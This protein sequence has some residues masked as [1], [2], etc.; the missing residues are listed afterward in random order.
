MPVLK[1]QKIPKKQLSSGYILARFCYY[2]P[3]YTFEQA[4]RL[5]YKRVGQLL[6]AVDREYARK[7]IDLLNIVASPHTKNPKEA[8]G[9]LRDIFEQMMS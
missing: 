4:R 8:I 3:Q 5:P 2:F 7:M 1:A 9:N 6:K